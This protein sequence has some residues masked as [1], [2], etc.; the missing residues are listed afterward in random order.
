VADTE[1][2]F[3]SRYDFNSVFLQVV[4]LESTP[5]QALLANGMGRR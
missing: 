5:H 4:I 1:M 3:S 2:S